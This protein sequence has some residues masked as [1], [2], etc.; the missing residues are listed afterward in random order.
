MVSA[1]FVAWQ[2]H[3]ANAD[4]SRGGGGGGGG[5]SRSDSFE[6]SSSISSGRSEEGGSSNGITMLM[7]MANCAELMRSSSPDM[8]PMTMA[9][10]TALQ[11][12]SPKTEPQA[13]PV[14]GL[15]AL[16]SLASLES[17]TP[18]SKREAI[19]QIGDSLRG[20]R[21]EGAA[22]G[23]GGRGKATK[24]QPSKKRRAPL[25]TKREREREAAAAAKDGSERPVI[26]LAWELPE[27]RDVYNKGGRV[28]I[29]TPGARKALLRRWHKKRLAR[30]W[31]K[32][33]RYSCRKNLANGRVRV[34]GRFVKLLPGQTIEEQTVMLLAAAAAEEAAATAAVAAVAAAAAAAVVAPQGDCADD[35]ASEG[36]TV[37]AAEMEVDTSEEVVQR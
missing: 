13:S 18:K 17:L 36:A 21:G 25:S 31:N 19:V 10:V 16:A 5:R 20:K 34:K 12:L 3:V 1:A 32:V 6:S 30:S 33:V 9:A 35:G 37:D 11:S 29:Y 26:L 7:R 22:D 8:Q 24:R 27:Y 23:G 4:R 28:G 2:Q 14:N 15:G